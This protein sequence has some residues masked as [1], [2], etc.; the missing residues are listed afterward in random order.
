MNRSARALS[1]SLTTLLPGRNN[2][3]VLNALKEYGKATLRNEKVAV[4]GA[5]S[6]ASLF[7]LDD[8]HVVPEVASAAIKTA[9]SYATVGSALGGSIPSIAIVKGLERLRKKELRSGFL[10]DIFYGIPPAVVGGLVLKTLISGPVEY[11]DSAL[12][13]STSGI[14]ASAILRPLYNRMK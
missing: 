7:L 11:L 9:L 10:K 14:I 2:G 3:R 12:L 4:I 13:L 5:L 6:F 8:I 1:Q